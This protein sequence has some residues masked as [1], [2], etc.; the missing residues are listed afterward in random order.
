MTPIQPSRWARPLV[1]ALLF[2]AVTPASFAALSFFDQSRQF[3]GM[4]DTNVPGDVR[5]RT[6][7]GLLGGATVERVVQLTRNAGNPQGISGGLEDGFLVLNSGPGSRATLIV[8]WGSETLPLNLDLTAHGTGFTLGYSFGD[9]A[10]SELR[11]T[12]WNDSTSFTAPGTIL[13]RMV[14]NEPQLIFIPF[15]GFWGA[16]LSSVDRV[17]FTL[18][19]VNSADTEFS[20]LQVV[21]EPSA[22]LLLG[23]SLVGATRP[24]RR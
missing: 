8:S 3:T 13:P 21:P 23:L 18:Q 15:S 2:T 11:L 24:R 4:N 22:L 12:V 6:G 19:S 5:Q 9:V 10:G 14:E 20:S 16:D 7:S 17:V 1:A